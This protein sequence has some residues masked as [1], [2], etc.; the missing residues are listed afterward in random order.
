MVINLVY[1]YLASVIATVW[2]VNFESLNFCG[3]ES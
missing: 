1:N 3:F 2:V